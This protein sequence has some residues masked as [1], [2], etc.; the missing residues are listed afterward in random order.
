M[1]NVPPL[2]P[3]AKVCGTERKTC[4]KKKKKPLL[5]KKFLFPKKIYAV[6]TL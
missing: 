4:Q 2:F 5:L 6:F 3:Q 1:K